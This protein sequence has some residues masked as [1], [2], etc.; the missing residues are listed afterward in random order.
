MGQWRGEDC[1]LS[2]P[3]F[4]C[5][6]PRRGAAYEEVQTSSADPRKRIGASDD[7]RRG[8]NPCSEAGGTAGIGIAG[9]G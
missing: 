2:L 9:L 5:S 1:P 4:L 7:I 6:W 8:G 3:F